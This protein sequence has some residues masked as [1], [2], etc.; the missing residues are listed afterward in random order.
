MSKSIFPRDNE[1]LDAATADLAKGQVIRNLYDEIWLEVPDGIIRWYLQGYPGDYRVIRV[2]PARTRKEWSWK[3]ARGTL[4][5][6]FPAPART[7][8][9]SNP[10]L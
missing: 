3:A 1:I 10:R 8:S 2:A 5:N 6:F 4:W 7:T 9:S